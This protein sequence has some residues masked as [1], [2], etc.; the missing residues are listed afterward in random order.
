MSVQ[1]WNK[2]PDYDP[3]DPSS[4]PGEAKPISGR[5][6]SSINNLI[7]VSIDSPSN[8]QALIYNDQTGIWENGDAADL[9][10]LETCKNVTNADTSEWISES[11]SKGD[12]VIKDNHL[13][14]ANTTTNATWT[15]SEWDEVDMISLKNAFANSI[16]FVKQ[17]ITLPNDMSL[18]SVGSNVSFTTSVPNNCV[19]IAVVVYVFGQ[20]RIMNNCFD[21]IATYSSVSGVTSRIAF[22]SAYD[23]ATG[24]ILYMQY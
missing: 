8:G 20:N 7:D 1:V 14:C 23:S 12:Y 9:D 5:V 4:S 15:A 13:Y 19:A 22:T 18:K 24:F 17:N 11:Y 21:Q 6:N 3:S 2:N 10:V 16:K